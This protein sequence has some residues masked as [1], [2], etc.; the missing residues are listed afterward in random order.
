MCERSKD[1]IRKSIITTMDNV[2]FSSL[3]HPIF[4]K[5]FEEKT[6]QKLEEVESE[7]IEYKRELYQE[8]TAKCVATGVMTSDQTIFE[9]TCN[10]GKCNNM[11]KRKRMV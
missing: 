1:D 4:V 3:M 8:L 6:N 2:F 9:F 11:E 10:E 5:R 7:M